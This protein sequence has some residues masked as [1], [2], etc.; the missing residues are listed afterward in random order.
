MLDLRGIVFD[1]SRIWHQ[2]SSIGSLQAIAYLR[3]QLVGS[4]RR[5]A[6]FQGFCGIKM[7][8]QPDGKTSLPRF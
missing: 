7:D 3:P 4:R 5:F 6:G 1:L 2:A 8:W